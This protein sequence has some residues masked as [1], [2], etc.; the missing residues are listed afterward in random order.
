MAILVVAFSPVSIARANPVPTGPT[1][2]FTIS[3][4]VWIENDS[5]FSANNSFW[6]GEGTWDHP[7]VLASCIVWTPD[8]LTPPIHIENT[9]AFF[10]LSK[11]WVNPSNMADL[12]WNGID[13]SGASN[14]MIDRCDVNGFHTAIHISDSSNITVASNNLYALDLTTFSG[15]EILDSTAVT[16]TGNIIRNYEYGVY[17]RG[18]TDS[19]ITGNSVAASYSGVYLR[20]CRDVTIDGN[21]AK[22]PVYDYYDSD[23]TDNVWTDSYR[24]IDETSGRLLLFGV[25]IPA[26]AAMAVAVIG[27]RR[28]N[29][30]AHR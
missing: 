20:G 6:K 30:N 19:R 9:T 22:T 17:A 12:G 14:G 4:G 27:L 28:R 21:T 25:V 23:W 26:C 8:G 13:I 16:A 7:Y 1:I 3:G 29:A 24:V 2:Y 15:I 18:V 10:R 11:I 5:G